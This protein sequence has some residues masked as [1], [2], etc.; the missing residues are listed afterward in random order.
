MG[1]ITEIDDLDNI[2]LDTRRVLNMDTKADL[3]K[4]SKDMRHKIIIT[5]E[6]EDAKTNN[7][8]IE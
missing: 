7:K 8:N 6:A 3:E 2:L 1:S 4:I 5:K